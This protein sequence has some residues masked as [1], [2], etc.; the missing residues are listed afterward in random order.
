MFDLFRVDLLGG[1]LF[2]ELLLNRS[3]LVNLVLLSGLLNLVEKENEPVIQWNALPAVSVMDNRT[4]LPIPP[5][6]DQTLCHFLKIDWTLGLHPAIK[7]SRPISRHHLIHHI[8]IHRLFDVCLHSI[9]RFLLFI[10]VKLFL[11]LILQ[12]H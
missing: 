8:L 3:L 12:I 7:I 5:F 11:Q 1:L 2:L 6:H 10:L 4:F 9:Y